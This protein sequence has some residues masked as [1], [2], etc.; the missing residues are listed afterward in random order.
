MPFIEPL[1][2]V[3]IIF[4]ISNNILKSTKLQVDLSG[5]RTWILRIEDVHSDYS[6]WSFPCHPLCINLMQGHSRPLFNIFSVFFSSDRT[7]LQPQNLK[8]DSSCICCWNSN[9]QPLNRQSPPI[10]IGQWLS[11]MK[12]FCVNF[13]L[14]NF[15]IILI[16]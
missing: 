2:L 8:N 4:A 1:S 14:C 13:R 12:I 9:S 11:P 10:Y 7:I 3:F 15:L 5:I 16:G 6:Q